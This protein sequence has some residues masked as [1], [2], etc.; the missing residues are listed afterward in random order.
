MLKSELMGDLLLLLK[1]YS[2]RDKVEAQEELLL[3]NA[4]SIVQI[5]VPKKTPV[6]ISVELDAI[7][8]SL[9]L[10]KERF[11]NLKSSLN[12][13]TFANLRLNYPIS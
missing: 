7:F 4:V 10:I 1:D 8:D 9:I 5:L 13:W 2:T 6:N 3:E 12:F 11:P